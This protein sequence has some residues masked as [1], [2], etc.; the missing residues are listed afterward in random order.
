[1][2]LVWVAAGSTLVAA[3]LDSDV[4]TGL[5]GAGLTATVLF[6][7]INHRITGVMVI[8]VGALVNLAALA[9]NTGMPVRPDALIA[10]RVVDDDAS[11]ATLELR[12][13]RHLET[14][15]DRAPWLGDVVPVEPLRAVVSFGDL[16]VAAGT[17]DALASVVRRRRRVRRRADQPAVAVATTSVDHDWGMAP[18]GV[19][20]S[21][22]QCSAKPEDVAPARSDDASD[23]ETAAILRR[24]A[25]TH[26]R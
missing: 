25:A 14:D 4:A 7:A 3:L 12:G 13:G 24:L 20:S 8:G 21:A 10:A 6:A 2:W 26:S 16:I 22:S 19:P 9:V 18:S 17:V 1:M 5:A 23:D 11:G 15:A